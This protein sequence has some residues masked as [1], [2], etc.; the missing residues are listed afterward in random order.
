METSEQTYRGL[1]C[2]RLSNG[3]LHLWLTKDIGLRIIGLASM[4]GDDVLADLPHAAIALADGGSY[5]LRGGHR[6]WYAPERPETTYIPDDRPVA[7][8]VGEH[9]V[10]QVQP[11]DERTGIQKSWRVSLREREGR[12]KIEHR[13]QNRGE[14]SFRLAPWAITM[15]KPGGVAICP[16]HSGLADE[17][18]VLPNR[19]IVLWPYTPVASPHIQWRDEALFIE[20]SMKADA[21]KIGWSNPTGWLA[22]ALGEVLFVKRA[23]YDQRAEYPDLGASSEIYCSPEV[24]ELETLGPLVELQPDAIVTHREEWQMYA[25]GGWAEEVQNLLSLY[26]GTRPTG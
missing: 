12:V 8:S 16:Q 15:L 20:A 10:T 22:Y 24:I 18:G 21:L 1:D 17:H 5:R 7:T 3:S 4:Q 6:L 2:I 26:D 25:Q 9:G 14:N 19:R 13:L 23:D 11:V